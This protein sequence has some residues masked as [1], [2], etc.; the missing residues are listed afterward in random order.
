MT[1]LKNVVRKQDIRDYIHFLKRE[2]FEEVD[3]F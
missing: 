1:L 2:G 3:E